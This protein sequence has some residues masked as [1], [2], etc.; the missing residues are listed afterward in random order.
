MSTPQAW[1]TPSLHPV[2]ARLVC[3]ELSR[4]GFSEASLLSGTQ[5]DREALHND[6]RFLSVAQF[7]RLILRAQS[8]SQCPWLGLHVGNSTQLAVHGALGMAVMASGTVAQALLLMQRFATL[9]ERVA[10]IEVESQQPFVLLLREEF[11]DI[12]VREYLLG[13][14]AG[15]LLRVL[16]TIS[17]QELS[18][19]AKISWPFAEPEWAQMY[20]DYCPQSSFGAT[21]LR[22]ELP[23]TLLASATLAPDPQ[24]Y[25]FAL[26]D[27]EQ[28]LKQQQRG[29]LS[30]RLQQRLLAC[31]GSYP[32]LE[33]MAAL[34]HMSP[35]T[36]IRHLREEGGNYQ[37]LLD[38]VRSELAC[39]LL[40]QTPLSIE[41]IAEQLGYQDSSNFSR[42]FRRWLGMTPRAFRHGE[43]AVAE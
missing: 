14:L 3:A 12:Q 32:S 24:T 8:L 5:L 25:R 16:E 6:N 43:P 17:G 39:W 18:S 22:V 11:P 15:G 19:Q 31:Q 38:H 36:L 28:Q 9:R 34:E 37:Q 23:Q 30:L 41:A 10:F 27:C 7:Q 26:R 29:S 2:Y 21:Q 13:H 42:T 1:L 35:R 40:L 20:R 33:Q 4:R